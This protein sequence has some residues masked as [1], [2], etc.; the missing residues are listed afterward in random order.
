MNRLRIAIVAVAFL[1]GTW[2]GL[3][4][5][6]RI[7]TEDDIRAMVAPFG[8]HWRWEFGTY[9][10]PLGGRGVWFRGIP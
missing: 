2:D 1:A 4:S 6:M 5:T 3:V 7:Y 10:F 8:S 9:D